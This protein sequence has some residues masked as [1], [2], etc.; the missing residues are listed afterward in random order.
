MVAAVTSNV[1]RATPQLHADFQ[2][3][4][5]AGMKNA[6]VK[7]VIRDG[8]SVATMYETKRSAATSRSRPKPAARVRTDIYDSRGR[9]VGRFPDRRTA[10]GFYTD[11]NGVNIAQKYLRRYSRR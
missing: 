2:K 8:P 4:W 5:R 7:K 11:R 3:V 10:E 9:P 6:K 1:V